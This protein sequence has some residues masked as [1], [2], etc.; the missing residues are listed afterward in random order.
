VESLRNNDMD[1]TTIVPGPT[2]DVAD[3]TS[4]VR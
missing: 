3:V 1:V 2:I 4:F